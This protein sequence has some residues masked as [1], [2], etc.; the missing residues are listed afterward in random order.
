MDILPLK[1]HKYIN[2]SFTRGPMQ[3]FYLCIILE[4]PLSLCMKGAIQANNL[5]WWC[6]PE[7]NQYV[8]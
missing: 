7:V 8:F 5:K 4:S 2:F 6:K 3:Y 1:Q